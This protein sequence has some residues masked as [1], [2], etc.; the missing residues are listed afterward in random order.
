MHYKTRWGLCR[1]PHKHAAV[2]YTPNLYIPSWQ[3]L[4]A[5]VI[6]VLSGVKQWGFT[7]TLCDFAGVQQPQWPHQLH[8]GDVAP[9]TRKDSCPITLWRY[10]TL[11]YFPGHQNSWLLFSNTNYEVKWNNKMKNSTEFC[12][13]VLKHDAQQYPWRAGQTPGHCPSRL[14]PTVW[15]S[16]SLRYI[17]SKFPRDANEVG[18][19]LMFETSVLQGFSGPSEKF[20][21]IYFPYKLNYLDSL[22]TLLN[23]VWKQQTGKTEE[24]ARAVPTPSTQSTNTIKHS[25]AT[26]SSLHS[27]WWVN[28]KISKFNI[29]SIDY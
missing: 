9:K 1:V 11:C 19:G 12:G 14:H 5:C 18:L 29:I 3:K 22:W 2:V 6:T 24:K 16:K 4:S 15:D 20:Q 13:A 21:Y 27:H 25:W 26:P 28:I 17:P 10:S 7:C 23:L 8:S